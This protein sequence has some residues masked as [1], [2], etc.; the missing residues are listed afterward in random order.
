M[1]IPY[2]P[3]K[4]RI[5]ETILRPYVTIK[6]LSRLKNEWIP[7]YETLADTGSDITLIPRYLGEMLVDD[8]TKGDYVEIKGIVPNAVLIA[9]VHTLKLEVYRKELETKIAI[10]DSDDVHPILG[11][12]Q[13]LDLFNVNFKK[14][15]EIEIEND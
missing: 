13:G 11:R 12:V 3:G 14:G 2:T 6:I 15:R 8:I 4:S 7:I 9:Y 5:F 10:A 1:K